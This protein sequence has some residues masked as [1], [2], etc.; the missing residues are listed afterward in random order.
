MSESARGYL[1]ADADLPDRSPATLLLS[2][3]D[4][5][6]RTA[7]DEL[8]PLVYAHLRA[9][10]GSLLRGRSQ[11]LQPTA[12]VHEAYIKLVNTSQEHWETRAHFCA[13][14]AIAM[15]QILSDHVRAARSKKRGGYGR[16]L[17]AT[18][19]SSEHVASPLD[20]VVLDETLS[21]LASADEQASRVFELHFFGGLSHK[22][23]AL[24]VGVSVPTIERAWRR[25]KAWIASGMSDATE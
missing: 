14:A 8:L 15:R 2:R 25:A 12:L 21:Q 4:H 17:P 16:N 22:E 3:I 23:A 13:V 18:L 9:V 6:D 7:A 20:A 1:P 10:A 24:V 19:L 11:T 5:G